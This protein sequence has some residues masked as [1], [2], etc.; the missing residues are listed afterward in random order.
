MYGIVYKLLSPIKMN[1][2]SSI[3]KKIELI[4]LLLKTITTFNVLLLHLKQDNYDMPSSV[5][6]TLR[7]VK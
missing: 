7:V 5:L 1:Q 4:W 6:Y 3:G 2:M